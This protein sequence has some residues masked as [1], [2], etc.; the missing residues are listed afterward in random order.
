MDRSPLPN[1]LVLGSDLL[2]VFDDAIVCD[3]VNGTAAQR[4]AALFIDVGEL[5]GIP[6]WV[7][8]A[9]SVLASAEMIPPVTCCFQFY[10]PHHRYFLKLEV[11]FTSPSLSSQSICVNCP[12]SASPINQSAVLLMSISP[13]ITFKAGICDFDVRHP[14]LLS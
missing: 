11:P 2:S 8:L 9:N 6:L 1:F 7:P 13:I 5:R 12:I 14:R 10:G 3:V 4:L